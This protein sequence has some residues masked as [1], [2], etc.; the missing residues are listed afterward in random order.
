MKNAQVKRILPYKLDVLLNS[1]FITGLNILVAVVIVLTFH[2]NENDTRV[3]LTGSLKI[4]E[5][6]LP[7]DLNEDNNSKSM[8]MTPPHISVIGM[9]FLVFGKRWS[10][11][12]NVLFVLIVL[13]HNEK[14][15]VRLGLKLLFVFTAPF[16]ILVAS[17]N[18]SGSMVGLGLIGLLSNRGGLVRGASWAFMLLRPQDVWA[19]LIYDGIRALQQRDYKAFITAGLI[20]L[21]PL[22]FAWDIFQQWLQAIYYPVFIGSPVGYSL[23]LSSTHGLL[24]AIGFSL[25]VT[26]LRLVIYSDGFQ[27][28]TRQSYSQTEIYWLLAMASLVFGSYVSYYMIWLILIVLP[29]FDSLRVVVLWIIFSVVGVLTMTV[30]NPPVYQAG[31]LILIVFT[32]LIA[33]RVN[34]PTTHLQHHE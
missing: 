28:R 5:N 24:Y 17:T 14:S 10:A 18:I 16:L 15:F 3:L 26:L 27:L 13:T 34:L 2:V 33:P 19:I 25:I 11:F 4:I 32:A 1:W 23:S 6:N 8:F 22:I 29:N 21:I 20:V 7:Y 30:P 12:W 9:P 31:M